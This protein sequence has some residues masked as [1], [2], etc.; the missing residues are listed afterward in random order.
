MIP[1]PYIWLVVLFVLVAAEI[2]LSTIYL[3]ALALG[4]LA[5][6][7]VAALGFSLEIQL[8]AAGIITIIASFIAH[9]FRTRRRQFG[10]ANENLD[11]GQTVI[12]KTTADDGSAK[13]AYRGASWTARAKGSNALTP[14]IYKI[15]AIE[16]T[17][18]I[19]EKAS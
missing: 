7:I 10:K 2:T 14:G 18:L 6:A 11:L 13:V 15:A 9:I 4:A 8:S 19:L 3:L 16:G 12:V 5:G 17:T 1:L